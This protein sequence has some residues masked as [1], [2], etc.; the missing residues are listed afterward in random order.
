MQF[1][2]PEN[3]FLVRRALLDAGR[4]DLIGKGP[5][6]LIPEKPPREALEA[7]RRAATNDAKDLLRGSRN[8]PRR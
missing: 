3:Y 8:R 6:C 1:F 5:K 7:R 2:L 4:R